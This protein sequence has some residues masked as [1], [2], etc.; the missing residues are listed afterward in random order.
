MSTKN[1]QHN[2]ISVE[3][4]NLWLP[5][6]LDISKHSII[7][8]FVYHFFNVRKNKSI[9]SNLYGNPITTVKCE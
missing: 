1:Q 9:Y 3:L 2:M 6:T 4:E 5:W 7:F 8:S